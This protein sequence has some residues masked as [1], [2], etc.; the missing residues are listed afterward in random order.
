M[1]QG[2]VEDEDRRPTPLGLRGVTRASFLPRAGETAIP[3]GGAPP[4]GLAGRAPLR[5]FIIGTAGNEPVRHLP[6]SAGE[7]A[8]PSGKLPPLGLAGRAPLCSFIIGVEY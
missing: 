4:L 6:S 1:A 7:T 8:R 2:Q 3:S 5:S